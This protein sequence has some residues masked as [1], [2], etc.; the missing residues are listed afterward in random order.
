MSAIPEA[1]VGA[2]AKVRYIKKLSSTGIPITTPMAMV[3]PI[4]VFIWSSF[5]ADAI[6]INTVNTLILISKTV[7]AQNC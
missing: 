6:S 7:P 5:H 2:G 1:L 3:S 4:N